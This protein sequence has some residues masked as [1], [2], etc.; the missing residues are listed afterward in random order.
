MIVRDCPFCVNTAPSAAPD[1]SIFSSNVFYNRNMPV[2]RHLM[3][4]FQ[5]IKSDSASLFKVILMF[6]QLLAAAWPFSPL[7]YFVNGA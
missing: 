4:F 5:L 1:A 7:K 3:L 2:I 6:F